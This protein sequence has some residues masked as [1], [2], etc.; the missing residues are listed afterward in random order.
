MAGWPARRGLC[1][2]FYRCDV[3]PGNGGSQ[4]VLCQPYP[5]HPETTREKNSIDRRALSGHENLRA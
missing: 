5:G 2:H 1:R 4:L 3:V